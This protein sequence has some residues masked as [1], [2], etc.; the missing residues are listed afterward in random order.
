M[1]LHYQITERDFVAGGL[2]CV[3]R[4][5]PVRA[6]STHLIRVAALAG[7]TVSTMRGVFEQYELWL[8]AVQALVVGITSGL[9]FAALRRWALWRRLRTGARSL[10]FGPSL[11]WTDDWGIHDRDIPTGVVESYDWTCV[12]RVDRTREHAFVWVSPTKTLLL[13]L[14]IGEEKVDAFLAEVNRQLRARRR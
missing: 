4:P 11:V 8:I 3:R 6:R 13:P 2:A 1:E 5:G 12:E 9:V 14:R 10:T 7:A